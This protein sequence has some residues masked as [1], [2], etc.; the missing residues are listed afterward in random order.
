MILINGTFPALVMKSDVRIMI[1]NGCYWDYDT[2][3]KNKKDI[4]YT[5]NEILE[6]EMM[7]QKYKRFE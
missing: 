7:Y 1:Q 5:Q 4:P 3:S 2:F 6:F